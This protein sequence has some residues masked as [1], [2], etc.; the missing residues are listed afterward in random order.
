RASLAQLPSGTLQRRVSRAWFTAWTR[1]KE[2]D[3]RGAIMM[4]EDSLRVI[5]GKA[6]KPPPQLAVPFIMAAEWRLAG[7]DARAADSLAL[8][9]RAAAGIDSLA[10]QRSGYVGRA[11]LVRARARRALGDLPA[12]RAAADRAIVA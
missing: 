2:G 3:T 12:A 1:Y 5:R 6:D 7:G 11:E 4:L 10:F 9:G 8:L